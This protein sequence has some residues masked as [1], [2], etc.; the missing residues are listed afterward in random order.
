M[1]NATLTASL[2]SAQTTIITASYNLP[3]ASIQGSQYTLS[4]F[5]LFPDFNYYVDQ[6]TFTFNPPEGATII[7]PQLSSL[8]SSSTLTR[9][10]F[11]DTLTI[12][13]D[14]IS[15]VDYAFQKAT[16]YNYRFTYNP[17]WVSFRPTFWVSLAAVIG[18]IGAVVYKKR[19]P[20]EKIPIKT[21]REKII[22]SKSN[23]S[24]ADA[25]TSEKC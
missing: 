24:T 1:A 10:S 15:Y 23:H 25:R 7:T 4:N 17:I 12:T 22:N 19:K 13:R 14:G 16:L 8:D 6:A 3:G 2:A 18:C 20:S 21:R 9:N 5:K 11:Q